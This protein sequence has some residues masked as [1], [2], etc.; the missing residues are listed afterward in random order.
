MERRRL[1]EANQRAQNAAL[2]ARMRQL[3]GLG[4][5]Y[6]H[7]DSSGCS[8]SQQASARAV[9]DFAATSGLQRGEVCT[10]S[11]AFTLNFC[12][13]VFMRDVFFFFHF[14][15]ENGRFRVMLLLLFQASL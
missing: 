13:R 2:E 5:N 11:A 1:G 4:G 6:A 3:G 12:F 10:T 8:G 15:V 14:Y 9:A 7:D